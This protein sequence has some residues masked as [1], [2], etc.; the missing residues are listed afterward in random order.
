MPLIAVEGIQ[1]DFPREPYQC[2]IE[3]MRKV[4]QALSSGKN[5]LLESP[6]G[7]GKTL[8][9]LCSTLAWQKHLRGKSN[10]SPQEISIQGGKVLGYSSE[11]NV[12]Q[13]LGAASSAA[14]KASVTNIIVYAT[15]THSQLAQIVSELR[16]TSYKPRMTVLGSREQL[17][18]H[19]RISKLR[20]AMLNHAC[21]SL[22]TKR[23]CM[24][25]NN[26]ENHSESG[27][28]DVTE[29]MDIEDLVRLGKHRNICPYFHTR[30][31]STSSEIVLLPYNYLLD[32]SIRQT[33]KLD[34]KQCIVIFD[35]AHN[36]ERVAGDAASF[37]L[38][39]ADI[40]ACIQELQHALSTVRDTETQRKLESGGSGKPE[41]SGSFGKLLSAAAPSAGVQRPTKESTA[42]LL[43]AM[44][45]L[46]ARLDQLNLSAI[47]KPQ[48]PYG[49][50]HQNASSYAQN[51]QAKLP[52]MIQ[53]GRWL[54]Q[55]L[56]FC[57][58]ANEKVHCF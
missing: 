40:A 31:F 37:S 35:E 13:P 1:V 58:F 19:E 17:C 14:D 26:L 28:L 9:L 46:E 56:S 33:L 5:A 48:Q 22:N 3:Y 6:T 51:S 10:Q 24:Y 23:G 12:A 21:N 55:L 4:L 29:P 15:R 16:A 34:W 7:T 30:E 44:F 50:A 2:Q 27:G 45:Q 18:V 57:G 41:E 42:N 53:P 49:A 38:T 47:A 36:L 8:A 43:R 25:R 32:S 39:S 54:S 52:G 11:V 20:G